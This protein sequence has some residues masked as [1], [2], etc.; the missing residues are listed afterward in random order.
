QSLPFA[1][2]RG[3]TIGGRLLGCEAISISIFIATVATYG[4][5]QR[6]DFL[7]AAT[8]DCIECDQSKHGSSET[9]RHKYS[10]R[11]CGE[12]GA[13]PMIQ[14]EVLQCAHLVPFLGMV[15]RHRGQSFVVGAAGAAGVLSRFT[16]LT[17]MKITKAMMMKSNTVCR[18]TP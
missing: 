14:T 7:T 15:E 5:L 3:E 6:L 8:G 2:Q 17:I 16:C 4:I 18:N 11:Y 12:N 13:H 1:L 9:C 10:S